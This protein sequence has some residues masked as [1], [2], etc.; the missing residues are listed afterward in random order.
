VETFS[1][2]FFSCDLCH[3]KGVLKHVLTQNID[4]LDYQTG[5]PALVFIDQWDK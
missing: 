3:D 4:G 5:I 2:P 1:I